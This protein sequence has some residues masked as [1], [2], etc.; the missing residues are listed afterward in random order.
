MVV[1]LSSNDKKHSWT[2]ILFIAQIRLNWA[3]FEHIVRTCRFVLVR[4]LQSLTFH[5][6]VLCIRHTLQIDSVET[7]SNTPTHIGKLSNSAQK[8]HRCSSSNNYIRI[9]CLISSIASK[10][11]GYDS[12]RT[13]HWYS[14][15]IYVPHQQHV[16]SSYRHDDDDTL[17]SRLF[18]MWM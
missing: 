13:R 16:I 1:V 4:L 11:M 12:V 9:S 5:E 7:T 14:Q 18:S 3:T 8:Q 15:S 6:D 2:L 10:N 17:P